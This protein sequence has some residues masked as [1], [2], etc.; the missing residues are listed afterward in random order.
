MVVLLSVELTVGLLIGGTSGHHNGAARGICNA[1]LEETATPRRLDLVG[2]EALRCNVGA[3][4][5]R[6][7][8]P[9]APSP[10]RPASV[11]R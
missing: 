3:Q 6:V 11:G 10:R 9:S 7:S 2:A 4:L 1:Q 5:L 8:T